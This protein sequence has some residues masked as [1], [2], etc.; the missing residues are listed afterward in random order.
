MN[1]ITHL[2]KTEK[3]VRELRRR[4]NQ[5]HAKIIAE[6]IAEMKCS[7]QDKQRLLNAVCE[8][9]KKELEQSK[10]NN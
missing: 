4:I 10:D 9:Y 3:G 5:Q 2:P 7:E 8:E 6:T 1:V